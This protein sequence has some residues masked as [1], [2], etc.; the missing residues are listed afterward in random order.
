[1]KHR[2]EIKHENLLDEVWEAICEMR[3]DCYHEVVGNM[4]DIWDHYISLN[5]GLRILWYQIPF[6]V[7]SEWY[8]KDMENYDNWKERKTLLQYYVDCNQKNNL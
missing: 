4:I 3:W 8:D 5:D 7:F 2:L 6:E 1:M